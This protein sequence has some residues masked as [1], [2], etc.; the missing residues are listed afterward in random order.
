MNS[1]GDIE[2]AR[3]A[4]GASKK[5]IAFAAQIS[6]RQYYRYIDGVLEISKPKLERLKRALSKISG[7]SRDLAN[8][9]S[10]IFAA[11]LPV[12]ALVARDM[13]MDIAILHRNPPKIRATNNAEWL[14]ASRIRE[15]AVY[16]L[17][18]AIGISQTDISRGLGVTVAAVCQTCQ[19][20]EEKR[21]DPKHP[22][23][24]AMVSRLEIEVAA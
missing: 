22:E 9:G 16:L 2:A 18:T 17:N 19:K 7:S 15:V 8:G 10:Y 4:A 13:D 3:E 1:I 20:I 21:D 11:Y 23:F 6:L 14:D 12:C 5:E 24:E